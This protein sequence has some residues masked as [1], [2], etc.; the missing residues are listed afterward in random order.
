ML[1]AQRRSGERAFVLALADSTWPRKSAQHISCAEEV[2]LL[3]EAPAAWAF[4]RLAAEGGEH[5][6]RAAPKNRTRI[7]A[8][9]ARGDIEECYKH[10]EAYPAR[11]ASSLNSSLLLLCVTTRQRVCDR[12]ALE[13]EK[14]TASRLPSTPHVWSSAGPRR[15]AKTLLRVL[16][17]LRPIMIFLSAYVGVHGATAAATAAAVA[18]AV[19]P[20]L[21]G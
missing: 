5:A 7:S 12:L 2:L 8:A 20:G 9:N 10:F 18:A 3:C 6:R 19:E 21:S 16:R 15:A 14:M 11:T 4:S 1:H 13:V 17:P